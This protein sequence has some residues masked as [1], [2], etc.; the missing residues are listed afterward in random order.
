ME[1]H[2]EL[3]QWLAEISISSWR[4]QKY[5]F[6]LFLS[7]FIPKIPFEIVLQLHFHSFLFLYL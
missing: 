3:W 4:I 6:D 2:S 1:G 7:V 5:L